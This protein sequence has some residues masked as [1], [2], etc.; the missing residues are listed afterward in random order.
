MC[1]ITRTTG[2]KPVLQNLAKHPVRLLSRIFRKAVI[3]SE[4]NLAE[5]V[6]GAAGAWVGIAL[7]ILFDWL[8][9][10]I[11]GAG[12]TRRNS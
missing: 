6:F 12:A 10:G 9:R 2:C 1:V 5:F 3:A 8:R 4:V 11:T 7:A